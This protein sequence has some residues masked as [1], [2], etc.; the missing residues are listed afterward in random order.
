MHPGAWWLWAL[1][2]AAAASRTTNPLLLGLV[3][4]VALLVVVARR[5][6]APWALGLR[7]YLFL[8]GLVIVIRLLF[9]VAVGGG[10]GTTVLFVLPEIPLPD[11]VAGIR[12]G[13]P[14]TREV[15]LAAFYDALRLATLLLCIGAA[16]LLADPKRLL[17]QVPA[18]LHELGTTVVV[19]LTVAPQLVESVQRVRRARRLRGEDPVRGLRGLRR[20]LVPV[21]EDALDRSLALAAAMDTRGYGRRA[22]VPP[23]DRRRTALLLLGGLVLL[24]VGTYGQ[25]DAASPAVLGL[26]ALLLGVGMVAL[27]LRSA[28]ARVQRPVHRPDRWGPT[29]TVV[30]AAGLTAAVTV[31]VA[32]GRAPDLLFPTVQPFAWPVLPILAT[33]G[34]LVALL[35][36]A[37]PN[38][39]RR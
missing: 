11:V 5:T 26:P 3:L 35:P 23:V 38:G 37:L 15:L 25:L 33:A 16:N 36:A 6:D 10:A 39:R 1:G 18:A 24:V 13:G 4:A 12:L 7:T 2:L 29:E 32:G 9:A 27:G 34:V 19:A 21:L 22:H 28:G 30:A 17:R 31:V 8:A 14:V 20:V